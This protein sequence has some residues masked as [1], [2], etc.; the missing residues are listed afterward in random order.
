M[1]DDPEHAERFA[2]HGI[3]TFDLVASTI[4]SRTVASGAVGQVIETIDIGAR[5]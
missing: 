2:T 3:L 1:R 5:R 4:R